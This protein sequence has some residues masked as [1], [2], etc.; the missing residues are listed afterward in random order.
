MRK[1]IPVV[2]LGVLCGTAQ[3]QYA[4]RKIGG[5]GGESEGTSASLAVENHKLYLGADYT[6]ARLAVSNSNHTGGIPEDDFDTRFIDLR[7]GYRILPVVGVEFHYGLPAQ[8]LGDPGN[9][10]SNHY[11]GIFVVPTAT[12]FETV[13]LAFPVGYT[14][15]RVS[16][17][18]AT[19]GAREHASLDSVAFGMNVELPIREFWAKLPD[20]RLTS[21]ASVY[22][23]GSAARYYGY[24]F[25][26]RYDFGL[27]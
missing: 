11:Y 12:L 15:S 13:E 10:K 7:A 22:N 18:D 5:G 16:H 8:G 26:L 24:R 20:L 2:L 25:G 21:G 3:A 27:W 9:V 4:G 17:K 23:H 14:W 1:L 19:T 6:F